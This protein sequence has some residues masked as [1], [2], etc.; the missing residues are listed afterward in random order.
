MSHLSKLSYLNTVITLY[1]PTLENN[2]KKILQIY[3]RRLWSCLSGLRLNTFMA[4]IIASK[5]T[6]TN[7]IKKILKGTWWEDVDCMFLA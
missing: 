4:L 1:R 5:F 2:I 3:D 6:M 7:N